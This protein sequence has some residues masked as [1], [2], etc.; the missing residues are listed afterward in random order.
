MSSPLAVIERLLNAVNAHDLGA[1]VDCFADDYVNIT[2]AHPARG[3]TGRDQ[4]RKNWAM[5]F[6]AVPDLRTELMA[7][8]VDGTTVWTEWDMSGTRVDGSPHHM[9]G[10]MI[11]EVGGDRIASVR[12]YLEPVDSGTADINA[13]VRL[14][15]AG[16]S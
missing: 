5:I 3:F 10:P 12:F 7:S 16:Q 9:R 11:F 13:A 8:A 14:H 4:V 2:P 15:T 6:G 1:L